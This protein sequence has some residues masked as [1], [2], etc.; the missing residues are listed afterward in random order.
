MANVVQDRLMGVTA[1]RYLGIQQAGAPSRW[2]F[3]L[4][5]NPYGQSD[6]TPS[7]GIANRYQST[8]G[9]VYDDVSYELYDHKGLKLPFLWQFPLPHSNGGERSMTELLDAAIFMQGINTGNPGHPGSQTLHFRANGAL[10]SLPALAA[11]YQEKPISA[12]QL[13]V[14]R[15]EFASLNGKSAVSVGFGGKVLEKVLNPFNSRLNGSL[16][17]YRES[18]KDS[19]SKVRELLDSKALESHPQLQ[20]V[21]RDKEEA[22]KLIERGFDGLSDRWVELYDKYNNLIQRSIDQSNILKGLNDLPIGVP[23]DQRNERY[24]K[25]NRLVETPDIRN[26]FSA[27]TFSPT[28]VESFA[29]AE[30]LLTEGLSSCVNVAVRPFTTGAAMNFDEHFSGTMITTLI[31]SMYNRALASC[32]LELIDRLKASDIF[33]GTMIEMSGEFN[34]SAKINGFGSDHGYHGKSVAIYSGDI[35]GPHF[36]GNLKSDTRKQYKGYWGMGAEV[37]ELGESLNIN[38]WAASS[39]MMLGVPSPVTSASSVIG[40]SGGVLKPLIS[41]T[42]VLPE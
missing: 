8:D 27:D 31:N 18:L 9:K 22:E 19:L 33:K 37:P 15:Y 29:M 2:T 26:L 30:Y 1:R 34:R 23:V 36:V 28:M 25:N 12:I 10:T 11:D 38:H 24:Y 21:I 16:K 17:D 40:N 13:G 3:D 7:P 5:L 41:Q 32:L 39:A 14:A 6:F 20:G 4:F 35:E 42:K